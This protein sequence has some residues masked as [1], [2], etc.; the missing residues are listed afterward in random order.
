MSIIPPEPNG[1]PSMKTGL[2]VTNPSSM[3]QPTSPSDAAGRAK[4]VQSVESQASAH[5][6]IK[7]DR[8]STSGVDHLRAALKAQPEVRPEVVQRGRA[9]AADPGYPSPEII[10]HISAQ[11]LGSPDLSEVTA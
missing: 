9:L 7:G 6:Q 10:R 3:I 5:S 4:A 11:I 8:L 1:V 2:T